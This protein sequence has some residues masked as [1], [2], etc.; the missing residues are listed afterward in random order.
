MF[1]VFERFIEAVA[2]KIIEYLERQT[3]RV[4]MLMALQAFGFLR[5]G[6]NPFAKG[7]VRIFRHLGI[8]SNRHIG[9]AAGQKLF[10]NPATPLD[11]VGVKIGG[12]SNK[13]SRMREQAFAML[14]LKRLLDRIIPELLVIQTL[15]V[16]ILHAAVTEGFGVGGRL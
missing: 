3:E 13:P 4:H 14:D 1:L 15:I 6:F 16:F 12:M 11:G 5:N 8:D 10:A 9:H 2:A 7:L